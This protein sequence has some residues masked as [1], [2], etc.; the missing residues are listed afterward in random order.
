[1]LRRLLHAGTHYANSVADAQRVQ[2]VNAVILAALAITLGFQAAHLLA[3]DLAAAAVNG[4]A[5]AMFLLAYWLNATGRAWSAALLISLA[6]PLAVVALLF[7]PIAI[8]GGSQLFLL[9]AA[10]VPFLAF[11]SAATRSATLVSLATTVVVIVD[12]FVAHGQRDVLAALAEP[13]PRGELAHAVI[14]LLT[15]LLGFLTWRLLRVSEAAVAREQRHSDALLLDLFPRSIARRLQRRERIAPE[16]HG[17]ASVLFCR[18][19]EHANTAPE[20]QLRTLSALFA[21][22]DDV[23]TR[24]GVEKIKTFGHSYMAAC[25]VPL[26]R[27]DHAEILIAA[28]LEML[29]VVAKLPAPV[30][31]RVGVHSG[32]VVAG[33]IGRNRY[34]YDLWGDVVNTAQRMEAH[35][36]AGAVQI[37]AVTFSKV[38]HRFRCEPRDPIQIKGKLV[39]RTYL[40]R[41]AA[42]SGEHVP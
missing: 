29:A 28:A 32:P 8:P 15:C 19:V 12:L 6:A 2:I 3:R 40:V 18:I 37:S 41:S 25:G 21:A 27:P 34:T 38:N 16:R 26:A 13:G 1:M 17:D 14:G 5:T 35:G 24:H 36:L 22:L 23:C 42:A 7:A 39:E 20:L 10:L 30:V 4:S 33:V 9:P 11:P 31:V